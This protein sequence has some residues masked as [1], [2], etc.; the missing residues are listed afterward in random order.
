MGSDG[1]YDNLFDKDIL[2]LV[3]NHVSSYTI[4]GNDR[5]P[6]RIGNLQPQI[7]ADV[8]ANAAKEISETN[9]LVDTPFQRRATAEGHFFEGGKQDDISV[10][11][12]VINDCEDSPD[13]RL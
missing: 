13:R 8:L 4:P 3:R 12:A 1:L 9:K 11:V 5:R 10:I 7:L 6:P 2:G